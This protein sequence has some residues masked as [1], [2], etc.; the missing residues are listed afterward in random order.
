[1]TA[2]LLVKRRLKASFFNQAYSV[3]VEI[4]RLEDA[5]TLLLYIHAYK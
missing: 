1:V 3:N 2:E 5:A 4:V